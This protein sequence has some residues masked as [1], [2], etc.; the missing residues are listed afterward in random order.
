MMV[1][2]RPSSFL[3]DVWLR[4][5]GVSAKE[6]ANRHLSRRLMSCDE[7]ACIVA[8]YPATGGNRAQAPPATG[9]PTVGAPTIPALTVSLVSDPSA[10]EQDCGRVDMMVTP[11][12]APVSCAAP[13]VFDARHLARTG[14]LA[15]YL[16]P[17]QGAPPRLTLRPSYTAIRPWT[18]NRPSGFQTTFQ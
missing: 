11:L 12:T 4:A 9:D 3:A 10:L 6:R 8:A 13:Y 17:R 18:P 7:Q 16:D 1:T 2:P 15:L 5:E 14:A